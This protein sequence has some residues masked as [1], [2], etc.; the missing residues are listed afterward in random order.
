ME[1]DK[2][3]VNET[4][5]K[6]LGIEVTASIGQ[7]IYFDWQGQHY[8]FEI[9][10]VLKDYHQ[11]SPKDKIEP[12]IFELATEE[13]SYGSLLASVSADNISESLQTLEKEWKG[14]I[15]DTPFE[16]SFLDENIK[17]QYTE[18]KKTA[19]IINTFAGI[20]LVICCLGLYGLSMY[21][22]ERR[23]KEIG[24]RKVL[25][26][27]V[28]QIVGLMSLEFVKLVIIA[29]LISIPISWYLLTQW[30][31]GGCCVPVGGFS[32]RKF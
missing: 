7:K 18:D 20:A 8:A 10:G 3:L 26:A 19:S 15:H 27:S 24:I 2:I 30:L 17:K 25:G 31:E 9:I 21:M 28:N 32:Y 29:L 6:K 11:T 14:L 4:S 1:A 23:F 22:A 13:N 16:Y 5:L 12:I